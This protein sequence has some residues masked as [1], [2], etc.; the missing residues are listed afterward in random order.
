MRLYQRLLRVS[1]RLPLGVLYA[2]STLAAGVLHRV[3]RYRRKVIRRNL[4]LC[5]PEKSEGERRQIERDFYR[6]FADYAVE[7]FKLLHITDEEMARRMRF[8]NLD[9]IDGYLKEGRSVAVYFSHTFNWEWAPAISLHSEV[10]PSEKVKYAQVYRPLKSKKFDA[11]MLDLR[12]RFHSVS[13]PKDHTVRQLLEWRKKGITSV[14]GFMSD[15]HPGW[16][17]GGLAVRLFG[18]PTMIISGTESLARKM[19]MAV[20]YW[21]M[22]R[23]GRGHYIIDVKLITPDAS[24]TS[25]GYITRRYAEL[26]EASIRRD[27]SLWL[28]SHNRWK[29]PLTEQNLKDLEEYE[30]SI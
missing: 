9:I 29:H 7:T 15:Q 17:D 24:A 23:S 3:V 6:R 16:G 11:L 26:L 14:T 13:V 2:M 10:K 5:F 19:Q 12:S 21:D 8:E 28:W 20:V 1:A 18:Q 27:P 30:Q 4:E 25:E 22:R